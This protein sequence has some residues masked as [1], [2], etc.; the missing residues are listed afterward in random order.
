MVLRV[1]H[2]LCAGK[3]CLPHYSAVHLADRDYA[4]EHVLTL[5][6]IRL[7]Q[8][9]LVAY[10]LGARFIR[11]N[12]RDHEDLVLHFLLNRCKS[13]HIFKDSILTISG[14][15]PYDQKEPVVLAAEDLRYLFI[16]FRLDFSDIIVKRKPF[17]KLLRCRYLP[18]ELHLH[19]HDYFPL[20]SVLFSLR[21]FLL[22]TVP[23]VLP[24]FKWV[25]LPCSGLIRH[26]AAK[27]V[28]SSLP[29]FISASFTSS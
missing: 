28:R 26:S 11:V 13:R 27:P 2:L 7:M 12:T 15:R 18:D 14:A 25:F 21:K 24:V 22:L 10:A 20:P 4:G 16:A 3:T 29:S 8:H 17:L 1:K 5:L 6:R 9:S 23:R 19:F